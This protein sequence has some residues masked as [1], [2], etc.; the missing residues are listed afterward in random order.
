MSA[1]EFLRNVTSEDIKKA[2]DESDEAEDAARGQTMSPQDYI[3][4]LDDRLEQ[5]YPGIHKRIKEFVQGEQEAG[6]PSSFLLGV[7]AGATM[8]A[9]DITVAA[10]IYDAEKQFGSSYVGL[11]FE[12]RP[13]RAPDMITKGDRN[14]LVKQRRKHRLV[15]L[16]ISSTRTISLSC[17]VR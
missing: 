5:D 4:R 15:D 14:G 7:W 17:D 2:S 12:V 1:T 9:H 6:N 3:Q 13:L 16:A 11:K 8:C 10:E